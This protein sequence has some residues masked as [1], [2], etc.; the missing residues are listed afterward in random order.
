MVCRRPWYASKDCIAVIY[1]RTNETADEHFG[2]LFC[3]WSTND[4]NLAKWVEVR[5]D[6]FFNMRNHREITVHDDSQIAN[7]GW[8]AMSTASVW[9]DSRLTWCRLLAVAHHKNSVFVVLSRRLLDRINVLMPAMHLI[10][11]SRVLHCWALSG[12]HEIWSCESSIQ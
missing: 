8:C 10:V 9:I 12:L 11:R 3:E 4:S 1:P 7:V 6:L 5:S 2:D